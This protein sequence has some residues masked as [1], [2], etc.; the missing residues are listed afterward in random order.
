MPF[1]ALNFWRN[2][3]LGSWAAVLW[4]VDSKEWGYIWEYNIICA[5]RLSA[6]VDIVIAKL[7]VDSYAKPFHKVC[8]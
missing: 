7:L 3:K 2:P 4:L 1:K 8:T 6:A 5:I